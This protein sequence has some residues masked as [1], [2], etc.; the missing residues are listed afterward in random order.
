VTAA[1][2]D[3][4]RTLAREGLLNLGYTPAEAERLLDGANGDSPEEIVQSA[5]RRAAGAKAA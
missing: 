5:L 2:E 3:G 4:P 1:G